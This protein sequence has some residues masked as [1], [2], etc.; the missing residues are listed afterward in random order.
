MSHIGTLRCAPALGDL[1]LGEHGSGLFHGEGEARELVELISA[2]E[3]STLSVD[4][5]ATQVGALLESLD[6]YSRMWMGQYEEVEWRMR[7]T[8]HDLQIIEA[9]QPLR[10][11]KWLKM[12]NLVLPE[13]KGMGLSVSYGIWNPEVSDRAQSAHDMKR[14]IGHA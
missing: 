13:L 10:E 12:R 8:A 5:N 6:F 9:D 3:L 11:R 2:P 4:L 1:G 14:V 7:F